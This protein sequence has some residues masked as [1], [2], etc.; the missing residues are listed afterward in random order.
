MRLVD[1]LEHRIVSRKMRSSATAWRKPDRPQHAP[2]ASSKVPSRRVSGRK[3]G[4]QFG[5]NHVTQ[6]NASSGV[7]TIFGSDRFETFNCTSFS[8][9]DQCRGKGSNHHPPTIRGREVAPE[10]T[11]DMIAG[12]RTIRPVDGASAT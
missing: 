2:T 8:N 11:E 4:R 7:D 9:A 6:R 10:G 12:R 5:L 1:F 3:P